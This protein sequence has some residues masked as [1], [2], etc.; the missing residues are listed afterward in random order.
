M[1]VTTFV[2]FMCT[3][4]AVTSGSALAAGDAAAGQKIYMA[5]C[6]T[7]HG[8]TG[9]GNPG[10]AKALK[11]EIRD[12]GSPEVQKKTDA[13]L[14]KNSMEGIGK[15]KATTLSDADA[16]NMVAYIRSLKK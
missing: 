2:L 5:K 6:K 3:V 14:K 1:R 11:T 12:L 16:D 15:M 7:C 10:M 4:G 13:E 8:A 9:Q